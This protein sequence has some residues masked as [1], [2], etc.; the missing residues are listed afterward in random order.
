MQEV[1]D[2]LKVYGV[3][4]CSSAAMEFV[5]SKNASEVES[6]FLTLSLFYFGHSNLF[7]IT[8]LFFCFNPKPSY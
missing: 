7:E 1:F 6:D 3:L 4:L 8:S 5:L 2:F